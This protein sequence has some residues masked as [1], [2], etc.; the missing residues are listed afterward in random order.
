[1]V[2][3][4]SQSSHTYIALN[5]K[6]EIRKKGESIIQNDQQNIN[7]D[8]QQQFLEKADSTIDMNF[9]HDINNEVNYL[10]TKFNDDNHRDNKLVS[11][12][13]ESQ[14]RMKSGD[15]SK[16]PT[17]SQIL[18][19]DRQDSSKLM[20]GE[21][22]TKT[23]TASQVQ[24]KSA[25]KIIPP[26]TG[27]NN[28]ISGR[29]LNQK[30]F[31][32]KE[33]HQTYSNVQTLNHQYN[34]GVMSNSD[35]SERLKTADYVTKTYERGHSA[36]PQIQ[37]KLNQDSQ[38]QNETISLAVL[39]QDKRVYEDASIRF[40]SS[41]NQQEDN[42]SKYSLSD[43]H[44]QVPFRNKSAIISQEELQ[45]KQLLIASNNNRLT[46]RNE[47]GMLDTR[48][49]YQLPN[50]DS[51]QKE[52]PQF[53][54]IQ[55]PT[56]QFD[57]QNFQA[58]DRKIDANSNQ[59]M[60][61]TTQ[62]MGGHQIYSDQDD[63]LQNTQNNLSHREKRYLN[64]TQQN[65]NQFND[66]QN[67]D[68]QQEYEDEDYEDDDNE[69]YQ[70]DNN[71][72]FSDNDN[73]E[74]Q[75]QL[76][77]V[78]GSTQPYKDHSYSNIQYQNQ[79]QINN[80]HSQNQ[81]ELLFTNNQHIFKQRDESDNEN[82]HQIFLQQNSNKQS[83]LH[84]KQN[85]PFQLPQDDDEDEDNNNFD[86]PEPPKTNFKLPSD[87]FPQ[88]MTDDQ[89]YNRLPKKY[90]VEEIEEVKDSKQVLQSIQQMR[91]EFQGYINDSNIQQKLEEIQSIIEPEKFMQ[92]HFGDFNDPTE[93]L[94]DKVIS[95]QNMKSKIS[96]T[97]NIYSNNQEY[98]GKSIAEIKKQQKITQ[99]ENKNS[100]KAA[101][102]EEEDESSPEK[103]KY[104]QI[105]DYEQSDTKS[106]Q[107]VNK[108]K[109][110]KRAA[111]S[112]KESAR[113]QPMRV[114]SAKQVVKPPDSSMYT[115]GQ[116]MPNQ[117]P[118]HLKMADYFREQNK[119]QFNDDITSNQDLMSDEDKKLFENDNEDLISLNEQEKDILKQ[120][121]EQDILQNIE[122][123][124]LFNKG[125]SLRF[126]LIDQHKAYK[127]M[128]KIKEVANIQVERGNKQI[129]YNEIVKFLQE[130]ELYENEKGLQQQQEFE[131]HPNSEPIKSKVQ[132]NKQRITQEMWTQVIDFMRKNPK[133][134]MQM[135]P[136][137]QEEETSKNDQPQQKGKNKVM[138]QIEEAKQWA[139]LQSL[140]K[141]FLQK[142][143]LLE[144][145]DNQ[146]QN[147]RMPSP[148]K[149]MLAKERK[150]GNQKSMG[151]NKPIEN[152][153]QSNFK[154]PTSNMVS[155]ENI[156]SGSDTDAQVVKQQ[157]QSRTYQKQFQYNSVSN[158]KNIYQNPAFIHP[159]VNPIQAQNNGQQQQQ[160]SSNRPIQSQQQQRVKS[161][162]K[163]NKKG[164]VM[165]TMGDI[166]TLGTTAT[167]NMTNMHQYKQHNLLGSQNHTIEDASYPINNQGN[168]NGVMS[169]LQ[170][171]KSNDITNTGSNNNS[172]RRPITASAAHQN[173]N[174]RSLAYMKPVLQ[175]RQDSFDI[176]T[177]KSAKFSRGGSISKNSYVK[178]QMNETASEIG[179]QSALINNYYSQPGQF[180][181]ASGGNNLNQSFGNGSIV[182]NKKF[183]PIHLGPSRMTQKYI[184]KIA[185][186]LKENEMYPMIL[187]KPRGSSQSR[188][189]QIFHPRK[190]VSN[191]SVVTNSIQIPLLNKRSLGGDYAQ[192]R[193]D[194]MN[195]SFTN[196]ST[197]NN[198]EQNDAYE[199]T[200]QGQFPKFVK[201]N[202]MNRSTY[203]RKES[204]NNLEDSMIGNNSVKNQ[205]QQ[206]PK[207]VNPQ[208]HYVNQTM[209]TRI[210]GVNNKILISPHNGLTDPFQNDDILRQD[211]QMSDKFSKKHL[212]VPIVDWAFTKLFSKALNQDLQ[213]NKDQ[214]MSI[215]MEKEVD[216]VIEMM[217]NKFKDFK[218]SDI[219]RPFYLKA[220]QTIQALLVEQGLQSMFDKM[221]K[222]YKEITIE[223]TMKL[224]IRCKLAFHARG[225][226]LDLISQLINYEV[227]A[228]ELKQIL[229][230]HSKYRI[231]QEEYDEI[232][233]SSEQVFDQGHD[234]LVKIKTLRSVHKQFKT[235]FIFKKKDYVNYVKSEMNEIKKLISIFKVQ[236]Q[237]GPTE[238]DDLKKYMNIT[239][240]NNQ[241]D[242]LNKIEEN[243]NETE[244]QS[245]QYSKQNTNQ[246]D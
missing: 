68:D 226:L 202:A 195:Q 180:D 243:K 223:N 162:I 156:N 136:N 27:K 163:I 178:R 153:T 130:E 8:G 160:M 116:T 219:M 208:K 198:Q 185:P 56:A 206:A 14:I 4:Y 108:I 138:Q 221:S 154:S 74:Q 24:T 5:D 129:D 84:S 55:E 53:M 81:G 15:L 165:S 38:S 150:I 2:D 63:S 1:M 177:N 168:Q 18:E 103:V 30:Q 45:Q 137:E 242:E 6:G 230:K 146:Q 66:D 141:N 173:Y 33:D 169:M 94:L 50:D 236:G 79:A 72:P 218:R 201:P 106:P 238:S 210:G 151:K 57:M 188:D 234:L 54:Q 10:I 125:D 58:L 93:I 190:L 126:G 104:N 17:I 92:K 155:Q 235:P 135:L 48:N 78:L 142:R 34:S 205:Q 147:Q 224:L 127:L 40:V 233:A 209:Q 199:Q 117:G 20:P 228:V 61:G 11:Q 82:D 102:I 133:L 75:T 200:P 229:D 95:P 179:N 144:A 120:R 112:A 149:N 89:I 115:V 193:Q 64:E 161:Q 70:D 43:N 100:N 207:F 60:F 7:S 175:Q 204:N 217:K 241:N 118:R 184:H 214:D 110:T 171:Y 143:D 121:M 23:V 240:D 22:S 164:S 232:K 246:D 29:Q 145:I 76:N 3:N 31:M 107:N 98:E 197:K 222:K 174:N 96:S 97:E 220:L 13:K 148:P 62:K 105:S 182:G 194:A 172:H 37:Q 47:S 113:Q 91:K 187:N 212:K 158:A 114:K 237:N 32:T 51:A 227:K 67:Q 176:T 69:D 211:S 157:Q 196:L 41:N 36:M 192:R 181:V 25:K 65:Q 170:N 42:Q 28:Q 77:V 80:Q 39:N 186:S 139:K 90:F 159:D 85:L 132:N 213:F 111:G 122:I 189:S 140:S 87:T 152:K 35:Y 46:F 183:A 203:S 71:M 225:M 215:Y 166:T 26:L 49:E 19:N 44:S 21:R 134:L 191:E 83:N 109:K 16:R 73:N 99:K 167:G 231:P 88:N 52:L 245:S 124:F 59:Q 123:N 119:Q 216:Y 9:L 101:I 12:G 131:V 239:T 86:M 128:M 244:E